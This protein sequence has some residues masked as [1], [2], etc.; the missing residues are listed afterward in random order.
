MAGGT[1]ARRLGR[2]A[3]LGAVVGMLVGG[4]FFLGVWLRRPAVDCAHLFPAA[5]EARRA[6]DAASGRAL[7]VAGSLLLVSSLGFGLLLRRED[8]RRGER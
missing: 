8:T 1:P 5:C 2:A 7:L 6:V 4:L 3:L